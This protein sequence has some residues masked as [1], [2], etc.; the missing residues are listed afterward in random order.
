MSLSGDL[1]E[2]VSPL[3]TTNNVHFNSM[4]ILDQPSSAVIGVSPLPRS[5]YADRMRV[6][7]QS[8]YSFSIRG[9]LPLLHKSFHV[10]TTL[11]LLSLEPSL[12]PDAADN[13]LRTIRV[14]MG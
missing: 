6:I 3:H 9:G 7:A 2:E 8:V 1:G 4:I 14:W 12:V 5:R 11:R 13:A 10:A